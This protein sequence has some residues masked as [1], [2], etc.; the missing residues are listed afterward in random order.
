MG[1]H[2]TPE[3]KL[4]RSV[5]IQAL[6]DAG[7]AVSPDLARREAGGLK[8]IQAE[9]QA[10]ASL[11]NNNFLDVCQFAG[12]DCRAVAKVA[13]NLSRKGDHRKT[14]SRLLAYKAGLLP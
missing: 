3:V 1:A 8:A 2:I 11:S 4:F 5:V 12:L 10:W 14:I 7:G 6:L 9:A 13:E